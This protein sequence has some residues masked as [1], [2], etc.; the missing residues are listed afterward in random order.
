M[1]QMETHENSLTNFLTDTSQN[2]NG[3]ERAVSLTAGGA[4]VML[5]M[6][7]GGLGGTLISVLGGGMLLRGAT[8]HCHMYDALGVNTAVGVPEGTRKSPFTRSSLLTG[9]VH[10]TKALTINKS[11]SELY[12]FWRNFEN[13]P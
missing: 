8:G 9:K 10:V 11:Q 12:Q 4:L 5:G 3:V 7:Y 13:L 1:H 6:K 2:V